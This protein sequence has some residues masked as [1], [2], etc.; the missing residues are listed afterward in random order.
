MERNLI[1]LTAHVTMSE[2]LDAVQKIFQG[3]FLPELSSYLKGGISPCLACTTQSCRAEWFREIAAGIVARRQRDA[4]R[5]LTS[6]DKIGEGVVG[7]TVRIF[8][9][10]QNDL[11]IE[12]G[13]NGFFFV[14][15]VDQTVGGLLEKGG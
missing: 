10:S 1:R 14:F 12:F 15:Q 6:V 11:A 2:T 4:T 9:E 13:P 8:L 5:L 3:C 7:L